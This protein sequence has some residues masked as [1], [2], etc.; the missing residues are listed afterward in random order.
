MSPKDVPSDLL[1]SW[2]REREQPHLAWQPALPRALPC[3]AS[4]SPPQARCWTGPRQRCRAGSGPARPSSCSAPPACAGSGGAPARLAMPAGCT[5]AAADHGL[6]SAAGLQ[7]PQPLSSACARRPS[8]SSAAPAPAS[9]MYPPPAH[10]HQPP[11]PRRPAARTSRAGCWRGCAACWA[12][13]PSASARPGPASSAARTR[14][15]LA[16]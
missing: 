6:S 16:G 7:A 2:L 4:N 13:Q 3:P 14:A 8:C 15:C 1:Q 12:A 9:S 11:A 5:G 10:P